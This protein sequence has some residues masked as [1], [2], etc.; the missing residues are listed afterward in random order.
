MVYNGGMKKLMVVAGVMGLLVPALSFAAYLRAGQSV[1]VAGADTA[2]SNAY[3]AGANVDVSGPVGGDLLVAGANVIVSGKV[4]QDILAGGGT[5][6][7]V[8]VS[9][10]DI[11]IAGANVTL[12]ANATGEIV[13]V[14]GQIVVTPDTTVAKDSYLAGGAV[15]F[16]GNEAGNLTIAGGA[17]RIDGVVAG[18]L[19]ITKATKVTIGSHAIINKNF[20]YSAPV[21]VVIEKGGQVV[22]A[23]T[24]HEVQ[25]ASETAPGAG[26]V[27]GLI[28]AW[29]LIKFLMTLAAAFLLWYAW[30]KDSQDILERMRTRF[31]H[32]LLR[33]FAFMILVPI[34]AIIACITVIGAIPGVVALFAYIAVMILAAPYA[35]IFVASLLK[36]NY[37][38]LA[39]YHLVLG[40][41][42]YAMVAWIPFLGW[43]ACFI[44]Y[45][46]ALGA[47]S[48]VLIGKFQNNS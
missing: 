18:N 1:F 34:A 22:G 7:V 11:R 13:A 46:V 32:K 20:E 27:F 38:N 41:A 43:I 29:F 28:T 19:L 9:A 8:G 44:V 26:A 15:T 40:A 39:W 17:V 36:K 31:W 6:N 30:P 3:V 42:I 25:A 12:S 16:A 5:V 35:A 45:L 23:T 10:Q 21:P 2:A 48:K 14:G 33:G 37:A 24:Y 47:L 4:S